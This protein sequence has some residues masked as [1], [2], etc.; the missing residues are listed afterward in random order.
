MT[1]RG[2]AWVIQDC[3]GRGESQ[4]EYEPFRHDAEDGYDTIEW[5]AAQPWSNRRVGMYGV[6]ALGMTANLAASLAPEPLQ[7]T[8]VVVAPASARRQSV[9]VGG[10]YRE[11]LNDDWLQG[12][13]VPDVS[14]RQR[15][16][17]PGDSFWD[18]REIPRFHSRMRARMY[19]V[20]GWYDPFVEGAIESFSGVQRRGVGRAAGGQR[21]VIG[22]WAHGPLEGDLKYRDAAPGKYVLPTEALRWF[23]L[24]LKDKDDGIGREDPV[25]YYLMGDTHNPKA[26]GNEWRTASTWPPP[27]RPRSYFLGPQR[28]LGESPPRDREHSISYI[29]DPTMPVPTIGG[30]NLVRGGKGPMDQRAI[31]E[32]RDY[33]RFATATLD[34]ALEVTGRILV[35]LYVESSARD[36][37]FTAKLVDVYP[38]GYEALVCDG[39]LRARYRQGLARPIPLQ[40]G[41]VAHLRIDLSS[42]AMVFDRG[43]RIALHVSSSNAPRFEPNPNVF[44]KKD[45]AP[46][47]A[48]NTI[49]LS[50]RRP[51]RLLLPVVREYAPVEEKPSVDEGE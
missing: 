17:P 41:E 3:R 8:Y 35:D 48:K 5:I 47:P 39:I 30:G 34:R 27:S 13:K 33:L 24:W 40:A 21:L 50:T 43:H 46:V 29:Y 38:D 18:W 9:Y 19:Q 31:P 37:D 11:E 7:C 4:G 12:Q 28:N 10:A 25:R 23:D 22:P 14:V 32:R 20:G 51:S 1:A 36:T 45:A 26:P 16:I 44:E 42:T 2:Y 49:H 15:S 6:S